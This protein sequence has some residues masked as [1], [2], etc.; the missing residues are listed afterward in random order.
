[1]GLD[2]T[3]TKTKWTNLRAQY[4]KTRTKVMQSRLLVKCYLLIIHTAKLVNIF[5]STILAAH[6]VFTPTWFAF[7]AMNFL[8]ETLDVD[9]LTKPCSF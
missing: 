7:K 8:G 5:Y 1:M 3:S 4:M 6:D 9:Q 2:V